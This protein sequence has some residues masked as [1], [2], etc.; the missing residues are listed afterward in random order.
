MRPRPYVVAE[1]ISMPMKYLDT[2]T[3]HSPAYPSNHALSE[4]SCKLL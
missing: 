4:S 2:E 1:E 3:A